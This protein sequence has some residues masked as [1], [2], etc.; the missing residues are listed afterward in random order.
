MRAADHKL[1][2][3]LSIR[4]F[5]KRVSPE[6]FIQLQKNPQLPRERREFVNKPDM[7]WLSLFEITAKTSESGQ[8]FLLWEIWKYVK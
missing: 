3:C 4:A 5:Q 7:L 1:K 8:K 6:K 2:T